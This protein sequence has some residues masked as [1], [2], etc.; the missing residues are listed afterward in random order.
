MKAKIYYLGTVVGLLAL[1]WVLPSSGWM[2][3]PSFEIP[4]QVL[5]SGG[6]ECA[7]ESY[8]QVA[9]TGQA[10][11]IGSSQSA[12]F[13]HHAGYVAQL[14]AYVQPCVDGDGDGY[15]DPVSPR[16]PYLELDCDDGDPDVNPGMTEG[17]VGDDTCD[18]GKDNDCNGL[19]DD[20]DVDNCACWDVDGDG[21]ADIACGGD[22][23]D[24]EAYDV[25]PGVIESIDEQ[26]CED[27]IDN[28]CDEATDLD[29]GGCVPCVDE[30]EDGYGFP[31]SENCTYPEEDCDDFESSVNPGTTE[32]PEGDPTCSDGLD[33]DCDGLTD[34]DP[35]CGGPCFIFV[36]I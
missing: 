16:C 3:S 19:F 15:G 33:N 32:G 35:E 22:D 10:S 27:G 25:N 7:S 28:D 8:T 17:P 18:D 11:A 2:S 26:N 30:D 24:D 36:T 9:A 12:N 6:G 21:H 4:I 13:R 34:T 5:D 29:D 14:A 23:C 20:D 1:T 31:A